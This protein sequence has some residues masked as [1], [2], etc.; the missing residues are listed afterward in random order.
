M[1]IVNIKMIKPFSG[2]YE[3][4]SFGHTRK[5]WYLPVG[6][7]YYAIDGEDYWL[8]QGGEGMP[9]VI[10]I[11]K[12]IEVNPN[13]A[14]LETTNTAEVIPTH[15]DQASS[16]PGCWFCQGPVNDEQSTPGCCPGPDGE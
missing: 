7:E 15:T 4:T 12:T 9:F 6:A 1:K 10:V 2:Y 16:C 3:P 8:V 11:P 5:K 14:L 13:S